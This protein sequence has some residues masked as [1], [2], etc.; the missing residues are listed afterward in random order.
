MPMPAPPQLVFPMMVLLVIVG[1]ELKIQTPPALKPQ[2]K[3]PNPFR[4]VNPAK[5][6]SNPS[7]VTNLTPQ[8]EP[9]PSMIVVAA[10]LTLVRVTA[11]PSKLMFSLYVPSETNTVSPFEAASIAAWI[12]GLSAGTRIVVPVAA[13]GG[14]EKPKRAIATIWP[15]RKLEEVM[16]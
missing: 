5:T 6:E 10:P 8:S 3:E 4:I 9:P 13:T 2:K 7:L 16:A 15:A 11:L 1:E 12:V 14:A